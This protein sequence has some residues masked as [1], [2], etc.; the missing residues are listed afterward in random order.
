[1]C[2]AEDGAQNKPRDTRSTNVPQRS[3]E[4]S[5]GKEQSPTG[6]VGRT[7][8]PDAKDR[9]GRCPTAPTETRDLNV[10]R[11]MIKLLEK[12]PAASSLAS[13]LVT[14][15][16]LWHRKQKPQK[17]TQTS[18]AT[19]NQKASAQQRDAP[20]PWKGCGPERTP[21]QISYL[22][23]GPYPKRMESSCSS[24]AKNNK[25]KPS[26]SKMNRKSA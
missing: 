17:Q 8:C 13:V 6:D 1:M 7:G 10:L 21:L 19:S 3:Q 11:G 5:T 9:D 25:N 14:I 2:G 24:R 16:S 12:T 22:V 18:G 23:S 15:F 26:D 4:R 20:T